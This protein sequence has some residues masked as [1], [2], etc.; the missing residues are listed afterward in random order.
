M[1]ALTVVGTIAMF[2]V[3]GGILVHGMP[4]MHHLTDYADHWVGALPTMNIL[5]G[6]LVPSLINMAVGLFA[7]VI[8]ALGVGLVMKLRQS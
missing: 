1:R 5:A 6:A 8:V 3:G 4:F 2:L 7:G